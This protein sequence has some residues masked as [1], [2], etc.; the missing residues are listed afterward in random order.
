MFKIQVSFITRLVSGFFIG[1]LCSCSSFTVEVK[2]E[3]PEV[4]LVKKGDKF[5][6]NLP[7]DHSQQFM[8][9]INDHHNKKCIDHMN[10]VWHGNEKGVNY[11]FEA[12][13]PGTDTLNFK[14]FKYNDE[15]K[16][17]SFI[18]KVE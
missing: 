8:W 7:E 12:L 11:N 2:K 15:V 13:A 17:V 9:R 3:A 10:S 1:A 6:I 14:Q 4:N 16:F 18:V 5:Y